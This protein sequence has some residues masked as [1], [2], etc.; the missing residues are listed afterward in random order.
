M[1]GELKKEGVG[2]EESGGQDRGDGRSVGFGYR[3]VRVK[4]G[5]GDKSRRVGGIRRVGR[6]LGC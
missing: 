6:S 1:P 2:W 5:I 4:M 3:K